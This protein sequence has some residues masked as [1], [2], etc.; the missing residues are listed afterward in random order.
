MPTLHLLHG[1]PGSGKTTYAA[2]LARELPAVRFSPDEWM[3]ALHGTNPPAATFR[4][5]L[6]KVL[7]LIWLHVERVLA[8][9]T[10][11]VFDGGFWR[12][13]ERDAARARAA[14]FG[15]SCQL[16][17]FAC[18]VSLARERTL[19]RTAAL[20][21]GALVITAETF[22]LLQRELEPVGADERHI[23]VDTSETGPEAGRDRRARPDPAAESSG[24]ILPVTPHSAEDKV[25]A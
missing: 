14:A 3:V 21:P 8:A 19:A 12:R 18:P 13:A 17:V 22:D 1:L 7:D 9:G 25:R 16:Y 10:D 11:V 15:V 4:A 20:P 24:V 5:E 6:A 2:R 23:L